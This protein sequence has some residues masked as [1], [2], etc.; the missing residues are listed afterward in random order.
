MTFKLK[1]FS[2][3]FLYINDTFILF[4]IKTFFPYKG[5]P[6]TYALTVNFQFFNGEGCQSFLTWKSFENNKR[7]YLAS[8]Y[9]M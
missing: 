8:C 5:E 6:E 9:P 1:H 2:D 7:T 3:F 4:K